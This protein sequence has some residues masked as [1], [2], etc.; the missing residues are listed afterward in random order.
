MIWLWNRIYT[1]IFFL[2]MKLTFT[3]FQGRGFLFCFAGEK[4]QVWVRHID[5]RYLGRTNGLAVESSTA[6]HIRLTRLIPGSDSW[7]Q[8]LA[9]SGVMI[10]V[11]GSLPAKYNTWAGLQAYSLGSLAVADVRAV[12][13]WWELSVYVSVSFSFCLLYTFSI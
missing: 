6:Y 13:S 9:N 2:S 1:S 10:Q 7:L 3:K 12:I 4:K 5:L 8:L 11:I